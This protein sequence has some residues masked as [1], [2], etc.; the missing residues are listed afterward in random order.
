G[1]L[2][3][4]MT[5]WEPRACQPIVMHHGSPPRAGRFQRPRCCEMLEILTVPRARI[6]LATHGSSDRRGR[7]QRVPEPAF[8]DTYVPA[9][10]RALTAVP[11]VCGTDCGSYHGISRA[12]RS[13][14]GQPER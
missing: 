1:F 7:C 2:A 4:A 13:K 3:L 8:M 5:W 12:S 10:A 6:E 9:S 14:H 11:D